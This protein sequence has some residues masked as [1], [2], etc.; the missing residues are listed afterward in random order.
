MAWRCLAD[1]RGKGVK[2]IPQGNDFA[3]SARREQREFAGIQLPPRRAHGSEHVAL[4]LEQAIAVENSKADSVSRPK[5]R[6]VTH[7]TTLT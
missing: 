4:V 7:L 1:L 6:P 2:V 3:G 5:S